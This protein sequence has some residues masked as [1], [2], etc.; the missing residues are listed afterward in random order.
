MKH[1]LAQ[2]CEL[3]ITHHIQYE[4][5]HVHRELTAYHLAVRFDIVLDRTI[6]TS[7]RLYVRYLPVQLSTVQL[8]G[9]VHTCAAVMS[10]DRSITGNRSLRF[11][12]CVQSLTVGAF[13]RDAYRD[14]GCYH[15]QPAAFCGRACVRGLLRRHQAG[16][17]LQES[18]VQPQL[19]EEIFRVR[20]TW[21]SIS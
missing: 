5:K 17:R 6:D 18:A 4:S 11:S 15:P 10:H 16:Q 7:V 13:K 3:N 20:S 21:T 14:P 1:A 19:G 9:T 8:Y 12:G 2:G